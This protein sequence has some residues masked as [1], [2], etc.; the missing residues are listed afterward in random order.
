MNTDKTV[1]ALKTASV[2]MLLLGIVLSGLGVYM[3]ISEFTSFEMAN[4]LILVASAGMLLM[5][6]FFS[7]VLQFLAAY[8]YLK[9]RSEK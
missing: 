5:A 7:F 1:A 2:L 9:S 3:G 4:V 8:L 6:C